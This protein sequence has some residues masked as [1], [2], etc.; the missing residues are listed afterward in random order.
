MSVCVLLMVT[1]I[2]SYFN[3]SLATLIALAAWIVTNRLVYI[4]HYTTHV[5]EISSLFFSFKCPI[6]RKILTDN[7]YQPSFM[8]NG[9]LPLAV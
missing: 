3:Y 4:L 8:Y 7:S 5:L 9:N 6:L 1:W 2:T